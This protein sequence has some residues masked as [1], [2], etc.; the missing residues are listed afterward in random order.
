MS[1]R[2]RKKIDETSG[3]FPKDE[4]FEKQDFKRLKEGEISSTASILKQIDHLFD[5]KSHPKLTENNAIKF[6]DLQNFKLFSSGQLF[7]RVDFPHEIVFKLFSY[8]SNASCD[9]HLFTCIISWIVSIC[10]S[11]VEIPS[12]VVETLVKILHTTQN[13]QTK[14][15]LLRAFRS[16]NRFFLKVHQNHASQIFP[17]F[18]KFIL[19]A[20]PLVRQQA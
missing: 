11:F 17:L 2:K 10:K 19:D 18:Q 5:P 1:L 7:S 4:P 8:I 9:E 3:N 20:S 6:Q 16:L 13:S 12:N 14:I 15:D